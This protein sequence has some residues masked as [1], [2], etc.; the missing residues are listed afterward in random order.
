MVIQI[1]SNVLTSKQ[2]DV[3][4]HKII[5]LLKRDNYNCIVNVVDEG[6]NQNKSP[7]VE[8]DAID[9]LERWNKFYKGEHQLNIIALSTLMYDTCQLL[10]KIAPTA[11][12]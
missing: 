1:K 5:D 11:H 3:L 10:E 8:S 12:V 4:S 9:L 6:E 7:N 2:T